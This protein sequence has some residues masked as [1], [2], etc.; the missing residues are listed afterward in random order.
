MTIW[1]AVLLAGR[2][3]AQDAI[4]QFTVSAGGATIE[5]AFAP[6]KLDVPRQSV[7]TWVTNA[8]EAVSEYFGRFPVQHARIL[9]H[10]PEG[11]SGVFHGTTYGGPRGAFTRISLGHFTTQKQLDDDW[12]MTHELTH[13]AF[14]DVEG[15]NREHHWME[16]GMATY[17]EPVARAQLGQLGVER[18]WGDLVRDIPQGLPQAG[19]QGLDHTPTWGRTYWGGALFWLLAD[20]QI[21]EQT[22][23]RK[24]LQDAMRGILNAGGNIL[25]DWSVERVVEVGDKATGTTVLVDLYTQMK[26]TPV[27]TDLGALWRRL[28]VKVAGDRVSFDD[29]APLADARKAITARIPLFSR[30]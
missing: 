14:P 15:E 23:N 7:I 24:G 3:A 2:A 26:A 4:P 9:I 6:G 8:A 29:Q 11:R 17:I 30:N 21:R 1:L 27:H 5:V 12:M 22:H 18:V 20:V 28:G 10:P 25:T 19:D 13:M 16:E